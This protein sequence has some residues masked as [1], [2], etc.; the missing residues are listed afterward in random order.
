M[1]ELVTKFPE[2]TIAVTELKKNLPTITDK[3]IVSVSVTPKKLTT[4]YTVITQTSS[5]SVTS[6]TY[7]IDSTTKVV[8]KIQ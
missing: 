2:T 5:S 7:S 6:F 4:E 3:E 1:T 8:E